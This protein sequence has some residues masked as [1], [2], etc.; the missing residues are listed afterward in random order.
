MSHDTA[1]LRAKVRKA[2]DK[3]GNTN[4]QT[5][6]PSQHNHDPLM[7]ELFVAAEGQSFFKKRYDDAKK[8]VFEAALTKKELTDITKRVTDTMAGE[9]ITPIV[10]EVYSLSIEVCR[11]AASVDETALRNYMRTDLCLSP[12][13]V[14]A[15]FKHAAKYARPA[16]RVKVTART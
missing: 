15:A 5:C 1:M 13:V 7:H 2:M 11:P 9:S 10:G 4:G 6:P 16:K 3:I 12:E 8:K 14:D